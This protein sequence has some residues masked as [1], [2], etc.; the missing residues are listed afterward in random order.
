MTG[1]VRSLSVFVLSFFVLGGSRAEAGIELG[2]GSIALG[3]GN[4]DFGCTGLTIA[5]GAEFSAGQGQLRNLSLVN[6]AGTLAGGQ[7]DVEV[8]GQ[9]TNA[10]SFIAGQSSVS[11][12]NSCGASTVIGGENDFW[13]L[14]AAG[15]TGPLIF[16]S[17]QQQRVANQL[18]LRGLD[19]DNLLFIRS[20]VTGSPA[21]LALAMA[22]SQDIFHVNVRDNHAPD[23][24]QA[25]AAGGPFDFQSVD[26]GGNSRWFRDAFPPPVPVNALMPLSSLLLVLLVLFL[27]MWRMACF[28]NKLNESASRTY[29]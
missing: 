8:S 11:V 5:P 12:T 26:A 9:W 20:S 13:N 10:G 28:R 25:L 22:G 14:V 19:V 16:E 18:V 6:N 23:E 24:G 2:G 1:M 15:L 7:A 29:L 21:F 17:G 3:G 4:I 27:G